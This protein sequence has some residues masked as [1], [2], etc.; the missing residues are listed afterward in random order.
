MARASTQRTVVAGEGGACSLP[1]VG[2]VVEAQGSYP[3][4]AACSRP[5][6]SIVS[7]SRSLSLSSLSRFL[8]LSLSSLSRFL[9]LSRSLA[10]ALALAMNPPPPP[11]LSLTQG[12]YPTIA[13][14]A[15]LIVTAH[16]LS[17]THTGLL[18][19]VLY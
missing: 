18:E 7:L 6:L 11:S 10:L 15:T 2:G 4:M 17:L 14:N 19:R 8:A 12:F 9:S 3:T 16:L 1:E 13:A 5:E